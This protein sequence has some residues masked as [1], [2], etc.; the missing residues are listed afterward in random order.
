MCAA[1]EAQL[2][3]SAGNVIEGTPVGH[4]GG[5][6]PRQDRDWSRGA[7]GEPRSKNP[8]TRMTFAWLGH[9]RAGVASSMRPRGRRRTYAQGYLYLLDGRKVAEKCCFRVLLIAGNHGPRAP[10]NWP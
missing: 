3:T 2:R 5:A 1:V 4:G 7:I 9:K 6:F 10:F 8:S